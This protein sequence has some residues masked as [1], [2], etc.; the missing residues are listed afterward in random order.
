MK[1]EVLDFTMDVPE[2]VKGKGKGKRSKQ[3]EK[4]SASNGAMANLDSITKLLGKI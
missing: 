2:S 1:K 4:S 3:Q